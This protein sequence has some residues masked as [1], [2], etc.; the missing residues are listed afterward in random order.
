MACRSCP[1]GGGGAYPVPPPIDQQQAAGGELVILEYQSVN[2]GDRTYTGK[3]T[4]T[5]YRFGESG[6]N[7]RRYV[8]RKDAVHLLNVMEGGKRLFVE[9]APMASETGAPVELA[10]RLETARLPTPETGPLPEA[11]VQPEVSAGP[12]APLQPAPA[13]SAP[14]EAK[15][16]ED[17]DAQPVAV[18]GRASA[19]PAKSLREL[20]ATVKDMST[21]DLTKLLAAERQ[22]ANR[23]KALDIFV[24]EIERRKDI[25]ASARTKGLGR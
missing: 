16:E 5:S 9:V 20:R 17:E 25:A 8:Y 10:P 11:Q 6:G 14:M 21:L 19:V 2:M 3:E 18:G 24:K 13:P 1:G 23:D 4:Q 22:G 12:G 15:A 7:R